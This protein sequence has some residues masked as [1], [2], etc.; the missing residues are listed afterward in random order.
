[1]DQKEFFITLEDGTRVPV[2]AEVYYEI[3]RSDEREKKFY[4][5]EKERML[6]LDFEYEEGSTLLDY[7][8]DYDYTT[9]QRQRQMQPED[10]LI[11]KETIKSLSKALCV[12]SEQF[13][14]IV[15]SYYYNEKSDYT[16]AKELG[17][18]REKVTYQRNKALKLMKNFL[19]KN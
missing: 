3:T 17:W 15:Y 6:S 7:E 5:R 18:N 9:V 11:N 10:V 16:I 1:M 19:E 13:R 12:L 2:T 4:Q 8:H 14:E